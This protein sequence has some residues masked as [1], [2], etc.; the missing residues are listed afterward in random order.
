MDESSNRVSLIVLLSVYFANF[1]GPFGGMAILTIMPTLKNSLNTDISLIVFAI[2]YYSFLIGIVQFFSGPLADKYGHKR[3]LILGTSIYTL[4]CLLTAFSTDIWSFIA[5]R[6]IQ[7]L[8]DGLMTPVGIAFAGDLGSKEIRGKILGGLNSVSAIAI[9]L[10]PVYGGFLAGLDW[11]FIFFAQTL[12][13]AFSLLLIITNFRGFEFKP[14]TFSNTSILTPFMQSLKNKLVVYLAILMLLIG[15][16]R[17]T[18]YTFFPDTL[19]MSP[20]NF[21]IFEIGIAIFLAN[22][23]GVVS[24]P[25]AGY[26]LDKI[27]RAKTI[28]I[29]FIIFLFSLL[30]FA[31]FD[32]FTFWA[33]LAFIYGFAVSFYLTSIQTITTDISDETRGTNMAFVSAVSFTGSSFGP[34]IFLPIYKQYLFSGV[35]VAMGFAVLLSYVFFYVVKREINKM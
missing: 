31:I 12:L 8:G 5:L 19:S 27:G 30:E 23:G 16:S 24:S 3:V 14:E 7:G 1:I 11:R 26:L 17:L 34:A 35:V 21:S 9:T 2:T 29:G 33:A 22:V 15:I 28:T 18:F 13:G 32:L 25:I 10:G 6:S 20:Y 4:G